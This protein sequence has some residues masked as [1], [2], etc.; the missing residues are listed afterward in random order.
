MSERRHPIPWRAIG[1]VLLLALGGAATAADPGEVNHRVRQ[2]DQSVARGEYSAILVRAEAVAE[3][4][5]PEYRFYHAD[6]RVRLVTVSVGHETWNTVHSYYFRDDGSLMKYLRVIQGRPDDPPRLAVIY[7]E[8]GRAVW[9]NTEAPPV[10]AEEV[11]A[12]VEWYFRLGKV[13]SGY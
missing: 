12:P 7:D 1:V 4:S 10:A 9:H 13:F 11:L 5:P 8:T 6:G 3:G 2:V